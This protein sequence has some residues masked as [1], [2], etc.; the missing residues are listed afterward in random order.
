MAK[1][2]KNNSLLNQRMVEIMEQV[3]GLERDVADLF[4]K[5]KPNADELNQATGLVEKGRTNLVKLILGS[6]FFGNEDF[7]RNYRLIH[8]YGTEKSYGLRERVHYKRAYYYGEDEKNQVLL[9]VNYDY[10]AALVR[11]KS[12]GKIDVYIAPVAIGHFRVPNPAYNWELGPEW[13]TENMDHYPVNELVMYDPTDKRQMTYHSFL[14]LVVG[15]TGLLLETSA[16]EQKKARELY[17]INK[18]NIAKLRAVTKL[19][20]AKT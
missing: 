7:F 9:R 1:T 10:H 16:N 3:A 18:T 12:R 11:C 13:I 17:Q 15:S 2:S 14:K 20:S 8:C 5:V 4:Q 19:K 6:Q